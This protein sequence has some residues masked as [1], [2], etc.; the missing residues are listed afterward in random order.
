MALSGNFK[1][2]STHAKLLLGIS[3]YSEKRRTIAEALFY[4]GEVTRTAFK[5]SPTPARESK[6]SLRSRPAAR[7]S[8]GQAQTPIG[9]G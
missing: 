5:S 4:F 1:S 6:H 8:R 2:S 9:D 3:A 7:R